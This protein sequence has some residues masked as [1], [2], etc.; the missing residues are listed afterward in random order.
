MSRAG[1][2][3]V[4][5]LISFSYPTDDSSGGAVPS[6]TVVYE[7]LDARVEAN[8][9]TMALLEQGLEVPTLF[10]VLIHPGNIEAK[11]NDQIVFTAPTNDWFYNK[12]FRIVGLTRSSNAA[13]NDRN[14]IKFV[15]RRW[16]ESHGENY[17]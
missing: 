12:K 15:V 11:H 5:S 10:Q 16:E 3:H 13:G 9:P 1:M 6:G 17:Q 14:L 7:R 4:C 8:M 2:T